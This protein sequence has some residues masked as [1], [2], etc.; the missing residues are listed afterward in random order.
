MPEGV[1]L[2]CC[3]TLCPSVTTYSGRGASA[4]SAR[5][6]SSGSEIDGV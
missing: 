5:R 4:S 6:D 2:A 3:T 1:D